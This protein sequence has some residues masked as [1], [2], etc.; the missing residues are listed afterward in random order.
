MRTIPGLVRCVMWSGSASACVLG[1]LGCNSADAPKAWSSLSTCLAG[2]AA[3][4][5]VLE[6]VGKLRAAQLASVGSKGKE[7]WPARCAPHAEALYAAS[8]D[9]PGLR[10]KLGERLGC[11]DEPGHC[12]LPVDTSL[13]SVT[14]ELWEAAQGAGLKAEPA[15]GI[16]APTL[17]APVTDAKGWKS[18]SEKPARV[19]GPRLTADGG[20]VLLL[21][22]K[23]GRGRPRFCKLPSGFSSVSCADSHAKVPDL[24]GQGIELAQDSRGIFAAGLTELMG[25]AGEEPTVDLAAFNVE[26]GERS[27]VRGL[28]RNLVSDGVAVES[29]TE[30][31]PAAGSGVVNSA[32]ASTTT[33]TEK[34]Y[35]AIEL[36][37]GKA[38]KGRKLAIQPV[39]A[40]LVVGGQIVYLSGEGDDRK[41]EAK[42]LEKGRIRD[43]ASVKGPFVGPFHS[44]SVGERTAVATLGSHTGQHGAK[45][46][47]D[48]D[49]TQFAI[50]FGGADD[51]S[52]A[53]SATLPFDRTLDSKL[54]CSKTA[55]SVAWV[56]PAS[57]GVEVGRLDCSADACTPN[58]VSLPGFESK[59]W[60]SVA[61]LADKVLLVWR[62]SLG[63]T[64]YRLAPLAQLARAPD[65]V[66]FDSP[67]FGG[68]N[69][70]EA[71]QVATDSAALLVFNE[72]QPI[73]LRIGADGQARVLSP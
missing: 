2:P 4:A 61:P 37:A 73:L 39:G 3:G 56:R 72:A 22:P 50:A 27:D 23:E 32:E 65:Q 54:V 34:G 24:P 15:A 5:P 12:V 7:S 11:T 67:D 26:T 48:K 51:W 60:W 29:A 63:D 42:A 59:W 41:L 14:T 9:A 10:R 31:T 69:A 46:T 28:A 21:A 20:A 19:V 8:A 47:L 49:K 66:L 16:A 52:K 18:V 25:K 53:L 36:Y 64:R 43:V 40:P 57:S 44:C 58:V 68:P 38:A 30:V 70:G 35:L 17:A 1:L 55:A 6:R 71:T 33:V 13:I 45:P 62:S